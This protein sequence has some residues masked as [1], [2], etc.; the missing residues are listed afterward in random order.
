MSVYAFNKQIIRKNSL[1]KNEKFIYAGCGWLSCVCKYRTS[2]KGNKITSVEFLLV[3][4]FRTFA[5][6]SHIWASDS[7]SLEF[8][9]IFV[10]SLVTIQ[11]ISLVCY[12]LQYSHFPFSLRH[13][14]MSIWWINWLS[15]FALWFNHVPWERKFNILIVY[16]RNIFLLL[17]YLLLFLLTHVCWIVCMCVWLLKWIEFW[18]FLNVGKY[19]YGDNSLFYEMFCVNLLR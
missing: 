17:G 19:L 16:L 7:G 14:T 10:R 1:L 5:A 13:H 8:H 3:L 18:F 11:Y 9:N 15:H 12:S 6:I 2:V 4:F